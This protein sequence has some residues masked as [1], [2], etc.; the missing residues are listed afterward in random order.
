M[1]EYLITQQTNIITFDDINLI[2]FVKRTVPGKDGESYTV[3]KKISNLSA[4]TNANNFYNIASVIASVETACELPDNMNTPEAK[5]NAE[6]EKVFGLMYK[7]TTDAAN[8]FYIEPIICNDIVTASGILNERV[9]SYDGISAESVSVF[10]IG[11]L[12][13]SEANEEL[14]KDKRHI[15][16]IDEQKMSNILIKKGLDSF[17]E[18]NRKVYVCKLSTE[19]ING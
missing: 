4:L 5:K 9:K 6:F 7:K 15:I 19:V 11:S 2:C 16:N 8:I 17:K 12:I 14:I 13:K 3:F 18:F 1:T 10:Q